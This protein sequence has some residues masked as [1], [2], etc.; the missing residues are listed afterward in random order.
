MKKYDSEYYPYDEIKFNFRTSVSIDDAVL[1]MLGKENKPFFE[2]TEAM[3]RADYYEQENEYYETSLL[4][5][6]RD[7]K[8]T[9]DCNYL[10][11]LD[12]NASPKEISQKLNDIQISHELIKR[13]YQYECHI[14]DELAKGP[15]SALRLDITS[16]PAAPMITMK[17]LSDWVIATYGRDNILPTSQPVSFSDLSINMASSDFSNR[18]GLN[19][20]EVAKLRTTLALLVEELTKTDSQFE[21]NNNPIISKISEAMGRFAKNKPSTSSFKNE[22]NTALD[23]KKG[24]PRPEN[25]SRTKSNTLHIVTAF[26]YAKLAETLNLVNYTSEETLA[27]IAAKL[28]K[29]SNGLAGQEIESITLRIKRALEIRKNP[30]KPSVE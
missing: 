1:A 25:L 10:N 22:I 23:V 5:V 15:K 16:T 17:S 3:R 19:A 13:A 29:R 28:T 26:V 30:D 27:C 11:A 18:K 7:I 8:N 2:Y 6:L 12:E 20:D 21:K 24:E 14:H 4:D 9:V